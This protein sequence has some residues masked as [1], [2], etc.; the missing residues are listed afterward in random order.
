MRVSTMSVD[1]PADNAAGGRDGAA[2]SVGIGTVLED[3]FRISRPLADPVHGGVLDRTSG[4]TIARRF[5]ARDK[6]TRKQVSVLLLTPPITAAHGDAFEASGALAMQLSHANCVR[7]L[8]QGRIARQA[9][10]VSEWEK[11]TTLVDALSEG[12]LLSSAVSF[13]ADVGRGLT[14]AHQLGLIHRGL[15][16]RAIRL[17]RRSEPPDRARVDDWGLVD[18]LD[19]T[20]PSASTGLMLVG[21]THWMSP[22]YIQGHDCGPPADLY[23]LGC[24]LFRCITGHAPFTGPSMKVM[25]QHVNTAPAAPSSQASGIPHWLDELVLG[26]LEKDPANRPQ[27]AEEVVSRL[28]EGSALIVDGAAHPERVTANAA[29][30]RLPTVAVRGAGAT[31]TPEVIDRPT[32]DRPPVQRP[33]LIIGLLFLVGIASFLVTFVMFAWW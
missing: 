9:Y 29:P 20:D 33:L 19:G 17:V 18:L 31:R 22:E 3:R 25:A 5:A 23:S 16:P 7:V 6:N 30:Q 12:V 28:E 8:G 4:I 13:M 21:G 14:D 32:R 15:S 24:I 10:R 26:L 27:T 1:P 2:L 11:H